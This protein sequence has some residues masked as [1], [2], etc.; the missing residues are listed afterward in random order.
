MRTMLKEID[1]AEG[2]FPTITQDGDAILF[3]EFRLVPV[4]RT[5][6]RDGRTVPVG[7]RALD[8]LMALI[9]RARQVVSKAE[10]FEI[11]WPN[12]VIEES[13]LRVHVSA[14]RKAL[15]DDRSGT[16]FIISVRG[17]G[18]AFVADVE[19]VSD[20]R[21]AV[22]LPDLAAANDR[23]CVPVPLVRIIGRDEVVSDIADDMQRKRLITIT[24]TGG[25]GKTA[26]A[27]AVIAKVASDFRDGVQLVDLGS[28]TS[29]LLVASHLASL[30]RLP[31]SDT[32][33]LQ[34]VIAHLRTRN[35]LILFDNCEHVIETVGEIAEAV[36][37][38]APEVRILATSRQPLR[39]MG[40]WVQ[41]LGPLALPYVSTE[42]KAVE[43][44]RFPAVQLFVERVSANDGSCEI[45]DS[46]ARTVA[47][48]CTR[49]DGLPLA[50]ELAATR[51]SFFGLR[52]LLDR[53]DDR[54]HI[55]TKGR[56][57]ALPRH[58]TLEAM[59]DWSYET[60]N[61]D[62]KVVWRRLAVFDSSFTIEAAG[63]IGNIQSAEKFNI[64]DIL[65]NLVEKSLVSADSNGSGTRYR[66]LDSLRLYAL[67]KLEEHDDAECVWRRHAQYGRSVG[68]RKDAILKN[69]PLTSRSLDARSF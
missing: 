10:L 59:I 41:R 34:Y 55:L 51:V 18:Y 48:I 67:N 2:N 8:I 68:N 61:D 36:L 54:F 3:G 40:E 49:L 31:A 56:R 30:L 28:L 32:Q 58:Q 65:D 39:A 14:L 1:T 16:R 43:A 53:L 17:R 6:T 11:V 44:L 50:I 26:V 62:E 60:L 57:T 19:R 64:V 20:D 23:D 46:D 13:A 47:E 66:L 24:G 29:P 25:I 63:A 35:L 5:L 7:D 4:T 21:T 38:G 33:P 52:G 15:G 22:G 12:T 37:Q 27:L 9:E 42:L 45:T 69:A